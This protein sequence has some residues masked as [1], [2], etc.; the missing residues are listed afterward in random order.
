MWTATSPQIMAVLSALVRDRT[1]LHYAARDHD[2]LADRVATRAQESG[3]ASLIDYYYHLR[4]D[5]TAGVEMM[6]LADVLV[7]NESYFFR[8]Q[9]HFDVIARRFVPAA[10]ER[11]GRARVWSAAC[12]SGEEPLTLAML[13]AD[14]G[15]LARTDILASDLSQRALARARRHVHAACPAARSAVAAREPLP[16]RERVG[17]QGVARAARR[18]HLEAAQPRRS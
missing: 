14:A 18:G 7:V 2:L 12:A 9:D 4:Y 10:I 11:H 6:A 3:F 15:L 5:D 8:E 17:D 16:G 1:G 13:L